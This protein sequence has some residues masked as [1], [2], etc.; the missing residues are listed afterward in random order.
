MSADTP[1]SSAPAATPAITNPLRTYLWTVRREVWENR[2]LYI[3]PLSVAALMLL[4]FLLSAIHYA[5]K[6][7]ATLGMDVDKQRTVLEI[8]YDAIAIVVIGTGVLV[9]V[10]FC[11]DALYGERRD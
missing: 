11:I 4:G 7:H 6:M 10:F 2:S 3:A 8:P 1:A 5:E 9:G